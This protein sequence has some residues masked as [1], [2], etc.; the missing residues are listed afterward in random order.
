MWIL[1]TVAALSFTL[2]SGCYRPLSPS[3][4]PSATM[5]AVK[6]GIVS[7]WPDYSFGPPVCDE[8][9]PSAKDAS[10]AQVFAKV[11]TA[12]KP[13][14]EF[15]TTAE[16][17]ARATAALGAINAGMVTQTGVDQMVATQKYPADWL[18]YDADSGTLSIP[19]SSFETL[20]SGV[21]TFADTAEK[22]ATP[23]RNFIWIS[24]SEARTGSYAASNA[25]GATTTVTRYAGQQYGLVFVDIP[26]REGWVRQKGGVKIS[27]APDRAQQIKSHI[28]LK[29]IAKLMPP[30]WFEGK[31]SFTP[32]LT[33]PIDRR[34]DQRYLAVAATCVAIVDV[35]T[36]DVLKRLK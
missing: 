35:S 3:E 36:G 6:P 8:W 17:N 10:I 23:S 12:V 30:G 18:K 4:L 34:T 16:F 9:L 22:G 28:G 5:G 33:A 1:A 14:G 11:K 19:I 7:R 26:A 24:E 32:T 15:E 29:I 25:F 20:A 31:F 2:L 21:E 27:L 13:R